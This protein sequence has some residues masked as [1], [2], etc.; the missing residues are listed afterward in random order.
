MA[1][2]SC[3]NVQT[4]VLWGGGGGQVFTPTKQT[5]VKFRDSEEL[6]LR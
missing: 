3:E 6:Y 5:S 4:F 2:Q 1:L